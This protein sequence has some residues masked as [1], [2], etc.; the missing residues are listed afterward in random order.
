MMHLYDITQAKKGQH[1]KLA[2]RIEIQTLHR[3]GYSNRSI[4]RLI[5]R[6]GN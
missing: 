5:K 4:A 2:E 1:L 6:S 3:Q